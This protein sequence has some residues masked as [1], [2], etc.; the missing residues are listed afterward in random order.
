M[1]SKRVS[2]EAATVDDSLRQEREFME[3]QH[4][5]SKIEAYE[6]M[7]GKSRNNRGRGF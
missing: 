6:A 7:A 3:E 1:I 5:K 4:M 2:I